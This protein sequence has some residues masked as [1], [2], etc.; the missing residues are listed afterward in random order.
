MEVG[1]PQDRWPGSFRGRGVFAGWVLPLV[2][3]CGSVA[4]ETPDAVAGVDTR[5]GGDGQPADGTAVPFDVSCAGDP[6]PPNA[7]DPVLLTGTVVNGGTL[8]PLSGVQVV[9]HGRSDGT[10]LASVTSQ[11]DGS[12]SVAVP[13]GG[14][15]R[16]VYVRF[17]SS[18]LISTRVYFADLLTES[19]V[20]D[21]ARMIGQAGLDAL[22]TSGGVT[23]DPARGT[24]VLYVRDCAGLPPTAETTMTLTP[25]AERLLYTRGNAF[26]ASA[27]SSDVGVAAGLNAPAGDLLVAA[28]ASGFAFEVPAVQSAAG[29]RSFIRIHP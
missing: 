24:V 8:M 10:P 4:D 15:P 16:A 17:T 12:F 29:E 21:L 18:G 27:T 2:L 22:Y 1:M 20:V 7:S 23:E 9:V 3:A 13:T 25:P 11:A 14:T 6:L 5:P 19:T 26:D 28:E